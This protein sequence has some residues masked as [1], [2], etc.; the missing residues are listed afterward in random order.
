M[1]EEM[2]P[3]QIDD[4]LHLL[5]AFIGMLLII[6]SFSNRKD[7]MMAW[8][9]VIAS[10]FYILLSIAFLNDQYEYYEI[11]LYVSGLLIAALTGFYC[12]RKL[13]SQERRIDLSDFYGYNYYHP[14]EGLLFFLSSLVFV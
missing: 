10:Q 2:I 12:L 5:F 11:L 13:R 4:N 7:A 8:Y 6:K 14:K 1:Y 9:M 3:K